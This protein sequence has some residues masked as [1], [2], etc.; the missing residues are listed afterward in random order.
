[1]N[2][3]VIYFI[4]GILFI[5][6]IGAFIF[7]GTRDFSKK[8]VLDNEKFDQEYNTV[9]KNNVFRYVNAAEVYSNLKSGNAVIF[10]GYAGNSW[11]GYYANILNEA[12]KESSIKEILYYDFYK[13]RNN[14]NATYQSIVLKLKDYITILDDGTENIYA[15]MLVVVRDGK[16]FYTDDET[17]LNKGV[18]N[19]TEYWSNTKKELKKNNFKLMFQ[20]YLK[21]E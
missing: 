12:A 13:D 1:M 21:Q 19:P 8:E 6:I 9:D 20:E 7:I 18:R 4:K 11:S 10:M 14:K 15:P 3:N 2:K 16:I 5:I 17:A